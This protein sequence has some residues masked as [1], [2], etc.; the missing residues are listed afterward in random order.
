MPVTLHSR[1]ISH[2]SVLKASSS[3]LP[4]SNGQRFFAGLKIMV[5]SITNQHPL[6]ITRSMTWLLQAALRNPRRRPGGR[7]NYKLLKMTAANSWFALLHFSSLISLLETTLCNIN[8]I[9]LGTTSSLM[10]ADCTVTTPSESQRCAIIKCCQRASSIY[11]VAAVVR[12]K[13]RS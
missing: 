9:N 7:S 8:L 13:Q 10:C 5:D 2:V 1:R 11:A 12:E 6:R 4:I 3:I